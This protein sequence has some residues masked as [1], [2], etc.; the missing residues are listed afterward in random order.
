MG[1]YE[2][3]PVITYACLVVLPGRLVLSAFEQ[4][5]LTSTVRAPWKYGE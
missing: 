5:K 2:P 3:E 4:N 1:T